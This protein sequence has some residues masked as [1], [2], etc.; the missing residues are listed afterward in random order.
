LTPG[1]ESITTKHRRHKRKGPE[2]SG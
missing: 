1:R 2:S